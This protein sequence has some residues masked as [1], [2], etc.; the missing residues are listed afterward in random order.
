MMHL[1]PTVSHVYA[2]ALLAAAQKTGATDQIF[3]DAEAVR[4]LGRNTRAG[5]LIENP[6]I[7]KEEKHRFI[8]RVFRGRIELLLLNFIHVMLENNRIENLSETLR[9]ALTLVEE[10]RG[11]IPAT[12]TTATALT[13]EQRAQMQ[14]ALEQQLGL[15]FDIRFRVDPN[16]LGGVMFK[17]R[18]RLLDGSIRFDL[19]KLR[20]RLMAVAIV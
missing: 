4:R 14:T 17:Y 1:D 12:V 11:I 9:L 20:E 3:L 15:R 6:R 16:V 18:D 13:N 10:G 19:Q 2:H 5:Q 7:P 8:D